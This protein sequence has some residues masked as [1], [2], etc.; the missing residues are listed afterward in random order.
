MTAGVID[1]ARKTIQWEGMGGLY[2]VRARSRDLPLPVPFLDQYQ[3]NNLN[4]WQSLTPLEVADAMLHFFLPL[5]LL[6]PQGVAS[7]L[8]GQMFFRAS[9]FGAFGQSKRWLG[10]NADGSP[11]ALQPIDFYKAG[12]MTGKGTSTLPIN[13]EH[14]RGY[15]RYA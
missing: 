2:K 9:L 14:L 12:A 8:V 1:C 6:T 3:S 5:I 11:R 13:L 10:T 15:M 7:P 4:V